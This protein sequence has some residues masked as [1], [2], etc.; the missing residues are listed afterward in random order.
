MENAGLWKYCT[1][2]QS[3]DFLLSFRLFGETEW[4]VE[5]QIACLYA[6]SNHTDHHYHPAGIPKRDGSIRRLWVPDR[7]LMKI[8]RNIL[9]NILDQ[10][11]VSPYA[12]AY[13]PGGGIVANASVHTGSRQILK[14]DIRDFFEHILFEHVYRCAFPTV[15]FP[16]SVGTL[17]TS[18][19]CYRDI[20]P[21]GAPTS[22][23]ISN[24]VMK[25][26]DTYMGSWCEEKGIRYSRYCDD[27]TFSGDFDAGLVIRKAGS[28]LKAMGFELNGKKTRVVTCHQRQEVTGIVVNQKPQVTKEFRRRLRQELYYC[29]RFGLKSHL[30]TVRDTRFLP[31]GEAGIMRY[32]LSLLGRVNYVLHVNPED[33]SFLRE[34]HRLMKIKPDQHRTCLGVGMGD[35]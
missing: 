19:C 34:K 29:R 25:P 10:M 23:A 2:E 3:R 14:L 22:A 35:G 16:P 33:V 28:F 6:V 15:Y 24:L 9:H 12:M 5:K 4:T 8:Q 26:F 18:L 31:Y 20:L 21:Q 13:H 1:P 32:W 11:P 17:L 27:L 7:L 30:E